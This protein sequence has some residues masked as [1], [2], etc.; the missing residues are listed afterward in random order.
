[1]QLFPEEEKYIA[2]IEEV[3]YNTLMNCI[4]GTNYR[5]HTRLH[6]KKDVAEN[7]SS[8]CQVSATIAISTLPQYIYTESGE[9][10]NINLFIPSVFHSAFADI[11]MKTAF[12][13]SGDVSIAVEPKPGADR[14][15]VSVRIPGWA[16]RE[17]ALFIN[18]VFAKSGKAGE[19]IA[20]NRKWKKGDTL[21]FTIPYGFNLVLYTGTDQAPDNKPRYTLLYGPVLM[22]LEAPCVKADDIPHIR[23]TPDQ[24]IASLKSEKDKPLHFKAPGAGY[25]YMPY[26]DAKEEGFTCVPVICE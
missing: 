6:G 16:Q 18:G 24:L 20:L 4:S 22:A 25:T 12:P 13:E 11:A 21:S 8:C 14:F 19:R 10:V 26:W 1:M 5:Y 23:M 3:V 9:G 2:E 7:V 15:T 17:T